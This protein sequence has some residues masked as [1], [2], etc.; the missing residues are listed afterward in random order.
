MRDGTC[1]FCDTRIVA[2]EVA[3]PG[4]RA[5][6]EVRVSTDSIVDELRAVATRIGRAPYA[7]E[8]LDRYPSRSTIFR[9]FG[10]W[11]AALEAAG[12]A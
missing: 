3:R 12:L 7:N 10:S 4:S 11:S 9:R 1:G 2:P 5:I 8:W 6:R